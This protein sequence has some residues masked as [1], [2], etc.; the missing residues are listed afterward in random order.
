MQVSGWL[1]YSLGTME[2]ALSQYKSIRVSHSFFRDSYVRIVD[3][4]VGHRRLNSSAPL[5][6]LSRRQEKPSPDAENCVHCGGAQHA[7]PFHES[8]LTVPFVAR[9]M[10]TRIKASSPNSAATMNSAIAR[11]SKI[12]CVSVV[13]TA[14][15][16]KKS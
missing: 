4:L 5:S 15:S 6:L 3:G 8:W 12:T 13:S 1:A 7:T 2:P 11:I 10:F 9:L 16:F 14:L